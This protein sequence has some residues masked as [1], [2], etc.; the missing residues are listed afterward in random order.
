V[1][2]LLEYVKLPKEE[3]KRLQDDKAFLE[4]MSDDASVLDQG[5]PSAKETED[6]VLRKCNR[7][8]FL[9]P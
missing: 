4:K 1:E 6:K 9:Q 3:A 2:E 5:N 7:D 8:I